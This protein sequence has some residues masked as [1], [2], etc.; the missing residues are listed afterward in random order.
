MRVFFW[1]SV[2][3]TNVVYYNDYNHNYNQLHSMQHTL[4]PTTCHIITPAII[5]DHNQPRGTFLSTPSWGLVHSAALHR[6]ALILEFLPRR[7]H[8]RADKPQHHRSTQIPVTIR[9]LVAEISPSPHRAALV[10]WQSSSIIVMVR[11]HTE[12]IL[13]T[14]MLSHRVKSTPNTQN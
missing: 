8:H 11:G 13:L 2:P 12:Y 6:V 7:L 14:L 5:I 3:S 1:F 4:Q 9:Y 10:H